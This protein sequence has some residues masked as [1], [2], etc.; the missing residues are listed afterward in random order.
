[1]A[2][3]EAQKR[4]ALKYAKKLKQLNITFYPADKELEEYL[5]SKDARAA[6]VKD[7]IRKAMNEERGSANA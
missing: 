5:F 1:M 7:L 2:K 4:A 3:T 6:F